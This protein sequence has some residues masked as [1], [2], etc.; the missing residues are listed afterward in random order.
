MGIVAKIVSVISRELNIP[1]VVGTK[2]VTKI[3]KNN[4][5][6]EVDA[7]KGVVRRIK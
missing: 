3:I 1:C 7:N 4:E 5:M 2:D 6:V